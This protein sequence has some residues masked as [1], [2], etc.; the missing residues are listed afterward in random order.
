[1]SKDRYLLQIKNYTPYLA[2][3]VID[4]KPLNDIEEIKANTKK[5]FG[6]HHPFF[7]NDSKRVILKALSLS[8]SGSQ[9]FNGSHHRNVT[10]GVDYY[11]YSIWLYRGGWEPYSINNNVGWKGDINIIVR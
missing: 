5:N 10:I 1:M 9:I 4:H 6:Y 7:R 2:L 3:I 11:F 8:D